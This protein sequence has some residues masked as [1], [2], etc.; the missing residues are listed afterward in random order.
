MTVIE[1]S[2]RAIQFEAVDGTQLTNLKDD[3]EENPDGIG[4]EGAMKFLGDI[5]V[6][7]DEVACLGVA[8]LLQSPS[9]GE[10]TRDGFIA[11][12]RSAG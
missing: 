5:Q 11:G 10:F 9:M 7:L 8:E 1:V 3:P 4:I 12:W 6:K 2:S